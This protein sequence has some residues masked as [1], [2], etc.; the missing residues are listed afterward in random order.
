MN[1]DMMRMIIRISG[2]VSIRVSERGSG[3]GWET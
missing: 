3:R 2:I 1:F